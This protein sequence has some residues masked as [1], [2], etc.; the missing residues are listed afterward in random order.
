VLGID[1]CLRSEDRQL[2]RSATTKTGAVCKTVRKVNAPKHN[3][4]HVLKR[5]R[6][7]LIG[8]FAQIPLP[9][10]RVVTIAFFFF[11]QDK[12][13]RKKK[14]ERKEKESIKCQ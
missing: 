4:L 10:G 12:R 13:E 6:G 11:R 14:K 5:G 1:L 7:Q 9:L 2:Q 3:P 8:W